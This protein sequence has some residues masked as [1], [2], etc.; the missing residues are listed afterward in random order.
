MKGLLFFMK[1]NQNIKVQKPKNNSNLAITIIVGLI[2]S[3][4]AIG[5]FFLLKSVLAT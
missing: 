4:I 2:I 1:I 3:G 5:L